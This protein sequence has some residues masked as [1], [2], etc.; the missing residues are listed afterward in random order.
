[1]I[2]MN[3]I[4]NMLLFCALL[5][6]SFCGKEF[7]DI[8]QNKRQVVPTTIKDFQGMLDNVTDLND[9]SS[10]ELS[11]VGSDEYYVTEDI[12]KLVPRPYQKNG[13]I[14]A[15]EIYENVP[16]DD[17]DKGYHRILLTNM[18]IEGIEKIKPANDQKEEWN[19]V[20]G[21]GLFMRAF[22]HYQLAQL[23]CK[24]Y[25]NLTAGTD[26]GIPLRLESDITMKSSRGTLQGVYDQ[27][28]SDLEEALPMLPEIPVNK[29]RPS[30]PAVHALLARI[31]L[32]LGDYKKAEEHASKVLKITNTL[33]DFN[34]L[35]INERY[36]FPQDLEMNPEILYF[37]NIP[38]IAITNISRFDVDK[39]LLSSYADDDLRRHV[40]WFNH[41]SGRIVFKGSYL[42]YGAFFT[43]LATDEVLL[44]RA[45][46]YA[47]LGELPMALMDL[48][49]LLKNRFDKDFFMPIKSENADHI[50]K[51]ILEE[52][53]K[54]LVLRGTRWEDLRRLNKE[55]RFA[56]T[57]R[58]E[59]G[60]RVYE[61]LPN[62][63]RYV[64]PIPANEIDLSG[65]EQNER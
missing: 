39:D 5:C 36:S 57:L 50:L 1:M 52:R 48:N 65:I 10:F 53:K 27:I 30:Q 51:I 63:K 3:L 60:G 14:W 2:R 41:N 15:E 33:I 38:N 18:A 21:S 8:K 22:N 24:P 62:S 31:Y 47:R 64:W 26:L 42:G 12:W 59:L 55:D 35:D 20:K 45:E 61:L 46:C 58:R 23:F 7:L 40:Y 16:G 49:K 11:I 56:I 28:I 9:F 19:N 34:N 17:W 13:Y 32:Q 25:N 4:K 44:T 43:G 6:F 37:C 54:E 29:Y